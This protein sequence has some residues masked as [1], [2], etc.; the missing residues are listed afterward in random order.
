MFQIKVAVISGG[1]SEEQHSSRKSGKGIAEALIALGHTVSI[2]EYDS[3]L[4]SNIKTFAPDAVFPIVQGKHHGDGAV[5]SILELLDIPYVGTSP[6]Y[7]AIINHKTICKNLWR[8]SDI[9]TPDYFEYSSSEY[10]KDNFDSF[11]AKAAAHGIMPPIVVKPP[12]QGGRYGMVFVKDS[13]SFSNLKN[14]F[15]YDDT[16]LA[17]RYVKGRFITQ[18]MIEIDGI[19]TVMPPVEVIDYADSEFK[20]FSGNIA[21][22]PFEGSDDIIDEIGRIT[23]KAASLTGASCFARLDYH[24]CGDALYLLEINAFPGLMPGYSSLIKCAEEAGYDYN[25]FVGTLLRTAKNG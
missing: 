5:Q 2:I 18:G 3:N 16:L 11:K 24:L 17:E 19:M 20:L 25:T 12:T 10:E 6:P 14:S 9:Q 22:V 8:L 15:R 1:F 13:R 7:A 23:L 4:I 21:V